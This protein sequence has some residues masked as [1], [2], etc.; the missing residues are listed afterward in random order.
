[1]TVKIRGFPFHWETKDEFTDNGSVEIRAWCKDENSNEFLMRIQD[2]PVICRLELPTKIGRRSITWDPPKRQEVFNSLKYRL[3]YNAPFKFLYRSMPKLYYYDESVD[4]SGNTSIR[5]Y[6]M[7]TLFFRNLKSMYY[8]GSMMKEP[9][10]VPSIGLLKC[11]MWETDIKLFRKLNTM[12][13]LKFSQW[14]E[15]D[16]TLLENADKV[17]IKGCKEYIVRYSQLRPIQNDLKP[18][19]RV[20]SYDIESYS[21]NHD[22]FP[23]EYYAKD[24]AWIITISF[25]DTRFSERERYAIVMADTKISK[26]SH[27]IVVKNEVELISEFQ[28][29]IVKLNPDIITG[30]NILGFDN[31]YLDARLAMRGQYWNNIGRTYESVDVKKSSWASGAYGDREFHYLDIPGRINVDMLQ[32]ISR[33]HKFSVYKLD[34]V[35]KELLGKGKHDVSPKDMFR[36]YALHLEQKDNFNS[37]D[38]DEHFSHVL[39]DIDT[40]EHWK[41]ASVLYLCSK[42]KDMVKIISDIQTDYKSGKRPHV[43]PEEFIV[44][45]DMRSVFSDFCFAIES[46]SKD[47]E[48]NYD[49]V[50]YSSIWKKFI[51]YYIGESTNK[52][53]Y[54]SGW[55]CLKYLSDGFHNEEIRERLKKTTRISDFED[56]PFMKEYINRTTNS[57]TELLEPHAQNLW[58]VFVNHARNEQSND[59]KKRLWYYSGLHYETLNEVLKVVEYGI[60][61]ADLP[62]DLYLKLNMDVVLVETANVCGVVPS[63]L[64]TRGQ[65]IRGISLVYDSCMKQ[66]YVMDRRQAEY[67]KMGGGYVFQPVPGYYDKVICYDFA[68]L[69]PTIIMALNIC[70]TTFVPPHMADTIDDSKCNV[71]KWDEDIEEEVEEEDEY[72]EISTVKKTYN[73]SFCY[74]FLKKEVKEGILPR[75]VRD[76]V[77]E[78]RRVRSMI[79]N[80]EDETVKSILNVRQLSLKVVCNSMYGLLGAQ[81]SGRLSLVEGASTVT[82]YGRQSIEKG[83]NYLSDK[84]GAKIVYGDTD[85]CF[86]QFNFSTGLECVTKGQAI[87]EE[88]AQLFPPPMSLDFEKAMKIICF[89]KKK[90]I[91]IFYA[92][93]DVYKNGKLIWRKGEL[94]ASR[95]NMYCR[96]IILSRR[97][98]CNWQRSIYREVLWQV[99]N[100]KSLEY[101]MNLVYE[102]IHNLVVKNVP[103]RDLVIVTGL[104]SNYKM[105]NNFMKVFSDE[106]RMIGKTAK[107]GERIPYVIVNPHGVDKK[108]KVLLGKKLRLVSTYSERLESDKPEPIDWMYYV[109]KKLMKCVDQAIYVCYKDEI[110]KNMDLHPEYNPMKRKIRSYISDTPVKDIIRMYKAKDKLFQS[111]RNINTS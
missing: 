82:A 23:T 36:I 54:Y 79:K 63:D 48:K 108:E 71:V 50:V 28:N 76:L 92:P 57:T 99:F 40:F 64:Y 111:I 30:Y 110:D 39:N 13:D 94:M 11:N 29:L 68:S 46:F 47:I 102:H 78:R 3:R 37:E 85:S 7:M 66:G 59:Y 14:F 44:E 26:R 106:L 55:D 1:M 19:F 58:E 5:K 88:F 56:I 107:P 75:L 96:G 2:Y 4:S 62:L 41:A 32:V 22:K 20:L 17:C 105:G 9:F 16:A 98:N 74:K 60:E 104:G 51:S 72:G 49:N 84:Y 53:Y 70:W 31:K 35:A 109:E 90:Y 25:Q 103:T 100:N 87:G 81:K 80:E 24:V 27:T 18:H 69:Y 43:H 93:E 33:D 67:I 65:Q 38:F 21:S 77:D 97:D 6:P 83:A 89:K 101:N 91:G 15:A 45:S 61:D 52:C 12:I 8:C 86:I 73:R 34:H 42:D 10:N 95:D